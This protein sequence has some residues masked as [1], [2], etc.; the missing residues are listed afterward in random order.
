LAW[1]PL[2]PTP[3]GQ[4]AQVALESVEIDHQRGVD[5]VE[6]HADLGGRA[7]GHGNPPVIAGISV[8]YDPL[9]PG[10]KFTVSSA[11]KRESI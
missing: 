8:R 10:D 2:P 9:A 4:A 6:G 11:D 7:D 3:V 1:T 5:L